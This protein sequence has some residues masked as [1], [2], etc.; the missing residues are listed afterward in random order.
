MAVLKNKC[1]S[2]LYKGKSMAGTFK[3]GDRLLVDPLSLAKMKCGDILV[4][5]RTN[6]KEE[7]EYIAHRVIKINCGELMVQGDSNLR[8]D[9]RIVTEE[10][11]LGKVSHILRGERTINVHGSII[12][13]VRARIIRAIMFNRLR[14]GLII[15]KLGRW[16]YVRLRRTNWVARIWRPKIQKMKVMTERGPIIKFT[17]KN[18]TVGEYWLEN[19]KFT[20]RK[21]YDLILNIQTIDPGIL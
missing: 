8:P 7:K 15:R 9:L 13:L 19:G 5:W 14:L 3:F 21:P 18:R 4:Y 12:G 17:V 1:S 20:C 6:K 16:P 11:F 10:N 2:M